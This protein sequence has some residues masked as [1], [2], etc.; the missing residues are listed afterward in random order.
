MVQVQDEI[1]SAGKVIGPELRQLGNYVK[2]PSG[3]RRVVAPSA[4]I[5]SSVTIIKIR[6]NLR[7]LS[8]RH[9][10]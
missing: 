1:F 8:D 2:W 3:P 4:G 10:T 9:L 6:K 5:F 7:I